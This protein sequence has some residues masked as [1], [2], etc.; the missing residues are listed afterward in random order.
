MEGTAC[1][2]G[3]DL[4]CLD[5]EEEGFDWSGGVPFFVKKE[6]EVLDVGGSDGAISIVEI[7]EDVTDGAVAKTTL[8]NAERRFVGVGNSTVEGFFDDSVDD[9]MVGP[10]DEV[11]RV[12]G[13]DDGPIV[14]IEK[15]KAA[16]IVDDVVVWCGAR[17]RWI[18]VR[19]R[20]GHGVFAAVHEDPGVG[21]GGGR[22]VGD[23]HHF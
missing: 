21:H 18:D 6:G 4:L 11:G 23:G 22:R 12:L 14:V 17:I 13:F 8:S 3:E 7:V 15:M 9:F 16:G 5:V 20:R 19:S 1:L 10:H 2:C